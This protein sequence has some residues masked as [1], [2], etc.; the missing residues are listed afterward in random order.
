VHSSIYGS[1]AS[2]PLMKS[3]GQPFLASQAAWMHGG[4]STQPPLAQ[5]RSK[6]VYSERLKKRKDAQHEANI[7]RLRRSRDN[8]ER[9]YARA[10]RNLQ[11][12]HRAQRMDES[13]NAQRAAVLLEVQQ[14]R[15]R[16]RH[17]RRIEEIG[18]SVASPSPDREWKAKEL[19]DDRRLCKFQ[20][21]KGQFKTPD[22]NAYYPSVTLTKR[23]APATGFGSAQRFQFL[24]TN[25]KRE[26][27]LPGPGEY[28][29]DHT[30]REPWHQSGK[31]TTQKGGKISSSNVNESHH[32]EFF[33][34]IV[35]RSKDPSKCTP[36]PAWV[37][38]R[39][40]MGARDA[41]SYRTS[42]APSKFK[43]A[44]PKTSLEELMHWSSKLPGVGAHDLDRSLTNAMTEH[45][46]GKTSGGKFSD[47]SPPTFIQLEERR[48]AHIPGPHYDV[49]G[50][51]PG[52]ILRDA[53][54]NRI[55]PNARTTYVEFAMSS[56]R[57]HQLQRQ[58]KPGSARAPP[59]GTY[60]NTQTFK[61]ELQASKRAKGAVDSLGRQSEGYLNPT[62]ANALHH[63][64]G[65]LPPKV[66]PRR[67]VTPWRG[68]AKLAVSE[69]GRL[70]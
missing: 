11:A 51:V 18:G 23:A 56:S 55:N 70:L 50:V 43:E 16:V 25:L 61:E 12:E 53:I 52:D 63:K 36:G 9:Q 27:Q 26:T 30:N 13:E 62:T 58:N 39:Q 19:W 38:P 49:P 64:L 2:T 3:N 68:S 24:N 45:I 17:Q 40:L 37:S 14:R 42:V 65:H 46:K 54:P 35:K 8:L 33:N 4:S 59:P 47:A 1:T 66:E 20:D 7:E 31:A 22:P 48:V 67:V 57:S 5:R 69:L 44:R 10:Q 34:E 29:R 41:T 21:P 32:I 28:P 60:F 6:S 15:R